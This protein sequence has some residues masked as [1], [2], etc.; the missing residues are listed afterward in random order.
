MSRG[1]GEKETNSPTGQ[2]RGRKSKN[3]AKQAKRPQMIHTEKATSEGSTISGGGLGGN[4]KK[5]KSIIN[6]TQSSNIDILPKSSTIV[7]DYDII[8]PASHPPK[9]I[10]S[11]PLHI[12]Q[13]QDNR[14]HQ[15]LNHDHHQLQNQQLQNHLIKNPPNTNHN[16]SARTQSTT[17]HTNANDLYD[18]HLLLEASGLRNDLDEI[19]RSPLKADKLRQRFTSE[20]ST[21]FLTEQSEEEHHLIKIEPTSPDL[22]EIVNGASSVN[23]NAAELE[24]TSGISKTRRSNKSSRS[25]RTINTDCKYIEF[26]SDITSSETTNNISKRS[27][28]NSHSTSKAS[29]SARTEPAKALKSMQNSNADAASS[30]LDYTNMVDTFSTVTSSS[31]NNN[32]SFASISAVVSAADASAAAQQQSSSSANRKPQ[33][34]F[35]CEM[36]CAIFSDRAQL[37][38]HVPIH[39]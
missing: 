15:E 27:Q 17:R 3:A 11:S 6:R 4:K 13:E 26:T 18:A 28:M 21:Q 38:D 25:K 16:T 34:Y 30:Y 31:T 10:S 12:K 36:C 35:E 39:I 20:S 22:R 7:D 29:K 2:T 37:L 1:S 14:Y 8:S 5:S 9:Q 32:S 24:V 19:L 23:A 33:R